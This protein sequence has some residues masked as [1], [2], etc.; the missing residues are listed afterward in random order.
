ME[1]RSAGVDQQFGTGD[2]IM[3][4]EPFEFGNSENFDK[5]DQ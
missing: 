1:I 5:S 2:D 3:I 4:E